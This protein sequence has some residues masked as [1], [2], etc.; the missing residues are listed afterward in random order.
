MII[1]NRPVEI[2]KLGMAVVNLYLLQS[3]G[4]D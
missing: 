3:L 4:R 1:Y 2:L